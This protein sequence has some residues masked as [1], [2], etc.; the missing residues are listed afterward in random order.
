MG[1]N[2]QLNVKV[3]GYEVDVIVTY[4]GKKIAIECKHYE[5]SS[6]RVRNL[7]HEWNSKGKELGF[8]KV[9]LVIVGC[10]IRERTEG[11][12]RNMVLP[13]GMKRS[14]IHSSLRL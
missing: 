5:K 9:V 12:Q 1:L 7:I 6:L 13:F 3:D 14:L 4:Q 11:L 10:K 8:D 2:P